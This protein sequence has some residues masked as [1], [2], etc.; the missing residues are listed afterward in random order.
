M[1]KTVLIV[2]AS[3]LLGSA[4]LE[5]FLN[6]EDWNVIAVSRRKPE[7]KT[8]RPFRYISLDLT[9]EKSCQKTLSQ[10][11]EVT[12]IVYAALY[13]KPE[14]LYEGWFS[15]EQIEKNDKMLR[16]VI[17]PMLEATKG[18]I[19]TIIIQG[20]K[21]YGIHL[22]PPHINKIPARESDARVEHPN[23]YWVQE[24]Y[25]KEVAN[26]YKGFSYTFL[27]PPLIVN[28]VYGAAMSFLATFGVYASI[29]KEL[30][31]PLGFPGSKA[32]N[33]SQMVDARL[34]AKM[35]GWAVTAPEAT[36]E[37]FNCTNGD[38]FTWRDIWKTLAETMGVELGD[39]DTCQMSA[40]LPAQ[41]KLWESIVT[42]YNL[43]SLTLKD[44]LK[45]SDQFADLIWGPGEK[46]PRQPDFVSDIKRHQAGFHEVAD[47]K[48]IV[49]HHL[50]KLI[51]HRIL[52]NLKSHKKMDF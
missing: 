19:R 41:E 8:K 46:E 38:V 33:V 51:D 14:G 10:I 17:E 25:I 31:K 28:G 16:N 37:T 47:S 29:C 15:K 32:R 23:F 40:F 48:E 21:A 9:D 4:A 3:G 49:K 22:P 6:R 20:T 35:I 18:K 5:H 2:G 30:K 50:Q 13:E 27:R 42:K 52:P 26:K 12:H 7:V 34:L 43:K 39:D 44:L 1:T 11:S 36:N 45:T 24:D